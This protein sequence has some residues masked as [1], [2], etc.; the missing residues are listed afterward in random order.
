M[1][2]NKFEIQKILRETNKEN[3]A[4]LSLAQQDRIIKELEKTIFYIKAFKDK[5]T[6]I[7]YEQIIKILDEKSDELKIINNIRS[8]KPLYRYQ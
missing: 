7:S 5:I 1:D 2:I 8:Q 6:E 3:F 4:S